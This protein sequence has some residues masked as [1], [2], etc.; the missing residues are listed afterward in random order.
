MPARLTCLRAKLPSSSSRSSDRRSRRRRRRNLELPHRVRRISSARAQS[1]RV[2]LP[3]RRR[4]SKTSSRVR[5]A[6]CSHSPASSRVTLR[7]G[8]ATKRTIITSRRT[9]RSTSAEEERRRKRISR[10]SAS[11]IGMTSTILHCPITMRIIRA[12]K[13]KLERLEIGRR[14]CIIV[15]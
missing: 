14:G 3:V 1:P 10:K 5:R 9:S 13:S 15:S 4:S 2:S 7:T 11:G 12:P 8:S 6:G